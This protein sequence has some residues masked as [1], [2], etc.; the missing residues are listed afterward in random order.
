MNPYQ[1][2][3][4]EAFWKLAVAE[5]DLHDVVNI[6]APRYE[7]APTDPVVTFG[8]CF[9]QHIGRALKRRGYRWLCTEQ[10][11]NGLGDEN[12]H[13]F[14]YEIFS[15]RTGNIYTTS[16]LLQ[17]T[18]WALGKKKHPKKSGK[19]TGVAMTRFDLGLS[20]MDSNHRKN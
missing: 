19:R 3:P 2:L 7:I 17:W 8:S 20:Q 13:R 4:P 16:L 11:P 18:E 9:A 1:T 15:A 14:N 6:W 12:T 5:R 10:R